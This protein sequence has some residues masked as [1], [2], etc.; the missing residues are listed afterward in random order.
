MSEEKEA[1]FN[2]NSAAAHS[3]AGDDKEGQ[4]PL[5]KDAFRKALNRHGYGFQYAALKEAERLWQTGKSQWVPW[6]PEFPVEVQGSGT[7]I[8]FVLRHES[9]NCYLVAECKRANPATANWCFARAWQPQLAEVARQSYAEVAYL[10]DGDDD[11]DGCETG[12]KVL[13][14]S[15]RIFQVAIEARTGKKGDE[16]AGGRGEIEDA[17]TQVCRGLN[18]LIEMFY[19][20]KDRLLQLPAWIGF[21]P[22]IFTTARLL[23]T[24]V[25]I[26]TANLSSGEITAIPS[27]LS[28][29]DWLWYDYPQS[30]GLKHA[31]PSESKSRDLREVVFHDYIRRIAIVG[32]D[33]LGP[34]LC[35]ETWKLFGVK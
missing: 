6:V 14:P 18:G 15:D 30:P 17:S 28:E 10:F 11:G 4:R 12:L 27:D 21:V 3:G 8:D 16:H 35:M 33:G 22:T 1:P 2:F 19:R 13:V 5:P 26:S 7:R 23:T 24:D 20:R 29:K 25:D 34:F 9:G 31:L 32:S